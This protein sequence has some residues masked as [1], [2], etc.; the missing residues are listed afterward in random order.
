MHI[1][2][3]AEALGVTPH[4]LRILEYQGRVPAVRRD[5]NGRRVYSEF[6][7]ALLRALGVGAHPRRLKRAEEAL[8]VSR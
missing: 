4:Y 6:D 7:L 2:A 1:G 5:L 3:A 8:G